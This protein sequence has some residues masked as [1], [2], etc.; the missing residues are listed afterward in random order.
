MSVGGAHVYYYR[1][2]IAER[3]PLLVSCMTVPESNVY[4]W[5]ETQTTR[6][7]PVDP[8]EE[9]VQ[10]LLREAKNRGLPETEVERDRVS[11]TLEITWNEIDFDLFIFV[12]PSG[13][14]YGYYRK[15]KE[16]GRDV[17][18]RGERLYSFEEV[19]DRIVTLG[20]MHEVIGQ[21]RESPFAG[22]SY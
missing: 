9:Q 15:R 22:V 18:S 10:T 14:T 6:T 2:P 12:E 16:N 21:F 8:A 3:E 7:Q 17:D 13:H 19:Y 4:R 1:S 5:I 11:G 20:S